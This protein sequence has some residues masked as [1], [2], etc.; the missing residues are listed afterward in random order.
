M[1][2]I[3]DTEVHRPSFWQTMEDLDT[4]KGQLRQL[5]I[6]SEALTLYRYA[7][8]TSYT[9]KNFADILPRMQASRDSREH[10]IFTELLTKYNWKDLPSGFAQEYSDI[11]ATELEKSNIPTDI[12]NYTCSLLLLKEKYQEA[13]ASPS[14]SSALS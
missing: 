8:A 7:P 9:A 2:G 3:L 12:L 5:A 4:L 11:I 13:S 14:K 1:K 6:Q 10:V